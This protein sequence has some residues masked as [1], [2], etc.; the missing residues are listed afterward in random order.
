MHRSTI[1][2]SKHIS[3]GCGVKPNRI[4]G[5]SEAGPYSLPWQVALVQQG[6]SRPFCGGTLISNRHVLTAAHCTDAYNG[7]W[8]V[9]VGEHSTT[10][11]SDGTRHT[12]CRFENHPQYDDYTINNDF[13]VVTL[14][15]PVDIGTRANYACLPTSGMG[16]NFLAGKTLTV[17][18]WGRLASNQLGPTVLHKVELPAVSNT[19]CGQWFSGITDKMLCAGREG[20][21]AV[22]AC[23]GD[24]GGNYVYSAIRTLL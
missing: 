23:N 14:S 22:G 15:Q 11:S 3:D 1:Q 2:K 4:V 19:A 8:D 12:K 16:G 10:S 17:S 5:G 6:S 7:E 24:S 13:A 9:I 21:N 20:Q 18:G